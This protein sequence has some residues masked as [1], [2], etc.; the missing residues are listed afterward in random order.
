[1]TPL[2]SVHA[3]V[4]QLEQLQRGEDFTSEPIEVLMSGPPAVHH[5]RR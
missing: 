4:E 1:V 3:L 5:H 2:D